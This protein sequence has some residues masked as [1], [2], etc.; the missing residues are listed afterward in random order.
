MLYSFIR[1]SMSME[2]KTKAIL[3]ILNAFPNGAELS[4]AKIAKQTGASPYTVLGVAR[5]NP[6]LC[7]TTDNEQTIVVHASGIA[8][9]TGNNVRELGRNTGSFHTEPKKPARPTGRR[10]RTISS[11]LNG[12]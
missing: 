9:R 5:M 1:K 12:E 7:N 6:G 2:T 4:V 8:T 10:G 3:D 11:H